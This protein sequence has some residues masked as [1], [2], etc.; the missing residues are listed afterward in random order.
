MHRRPSPPI[1]LLAFSGLTLLHVQS[2]FAQSPSEGFSQVAPVC[3]VSQ[4]GLS[5]DDLAIPFE[6]PPF[7]EV[8]KANPPPPVP[9]FPGTMFGYKVTRHRTAPFRVS[10]LVS[11]RGAGLRLPAVTP[12]GARA[13]T[14]QLGAILGFAPMP[15]L[16]LVRHSRVEGSRDGSVPPIRTFELDQ[17][18][19]TGTM[20]DGPGVT[21]KVNERTGAIVQLGS[22][23]IAES[24]AHKHAPLFQASD[25]EKA[26]I[27]LRPNLVVGFRTPRTKTHL[28]IFVQ[29]DGTPSVVWAVPARHTSCEPGH[30]PDSRHPYLAAIDANN[31][32]LLGYFDWDRFGEGL[33]AHHAG[34][35]VDGA[36]E[37]LPLD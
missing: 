21:L 9:A 31:L 13:F 28:R 2:A 30:D 27:E 29:A 24:P 1:G 20:T 32:A 34:S 18:L 10:A 5:K 4:R 33:A 36:V 14:A 35:C 19:G 37:E 7:A 11:E 3:P 23:L 25:A 22:S 15:A 6:P 26:L 16:K 8:P 17:V 12:A